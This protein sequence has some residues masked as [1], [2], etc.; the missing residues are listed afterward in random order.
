MTKQ[1]D[2][3]LI[4]RLW[5]NI[6]S[7]IILIEKLNKL[8]KIAMLQVL[9][10]IAYERTFSNLSFMKN[11][12]QNQPIIHLVCVLGCS[13][14]I[15]LFSPI[16]IMMKQL[17]CGRRWQW[18]ISR[19]V[20]LILVLLICCK[21]LYMKISSYG[22]GLGIG[23]LKISWGLW[24]LYGLGVELLCCSGWDPLWSGLNS[25]NGEC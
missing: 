22:L 21:I 20:M 23:Y 5:K 8:E 13:I 19:H 18:N 10:S 6:H 25:P 17:H 3:N 16:S 1:C 15:F 11:K 14:I 2:L 12:L 4:S 9:K 24:F 7:F